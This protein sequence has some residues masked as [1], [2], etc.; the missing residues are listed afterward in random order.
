M[1]Q[2]TEILHITSYTNAH[3]KSAH[4]HMSS[5]PVCLSTTVL[6]H[7]L[8]ILPSFLPSFFFFS[9]YPTLPP[10]Q[11][12]ISFSLHPIGKVMSFQDIRRLLNGGDAFLLMLQQFCLD[13]ITDARLLLAET[14]VDNPMFRPVNVEVR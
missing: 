6:S 4:V 12:C 7:S 14:Y 11:P 13:D 3:K 10:S 1:V 2:I 5:C 9:V 8:T